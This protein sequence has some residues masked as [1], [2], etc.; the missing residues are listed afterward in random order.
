M[1]QL[2]YTTGDSITTSDVT[3]KTGDA[4]YSATAPTFTGTGARLVTDSQI[5]G[6]ASF[7]GSSTSVSASGTLPT[8]SSSFSGTGARLVTDTNVPTSGSFTGNS[9]SVSVTGTPAGTVSQPDFSGTPVRLVTG[10]I[11]VP[12]GVSFTGTS[13][14]ITVEPDT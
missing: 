10:N 3:V 9:G 2:G 5:P 1:Y 11:E 8:I 13:A 12:S 4:S 6:S 7:S 14:T